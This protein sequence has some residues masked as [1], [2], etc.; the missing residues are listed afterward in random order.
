MKPMTKR[1]WQWFVALFFIVAGANHFLHPKPY[2]SMMPSYVPAH[3]AC[4][5][6]SGVAEI[7]GGIG[8]LLVV[9]RRLAAWCLIL[10]LIA[11]FPANLD[12]ALHGWP[13]ENIPLWLLW[14]RLP[15]QPLLGWWI[16]RLYIAAPKNSR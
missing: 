3:A 12:V 5:I 16:Y 8:V 15:F 13:G 9:T 7:M 2:L 1:I 11:V 10:L 6:V 14:A 4:V